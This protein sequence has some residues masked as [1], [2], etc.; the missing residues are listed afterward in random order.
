[1]TSD[2]GDR[3]NARAAS[4]SDRRAAAEAAELLI[5]Q[6]FDDDGLYAARSAVSARATHAGLAEGRVYDLVAA[7]HELAANAVQHGGGAGRLRLWHHN[8]ARPSSP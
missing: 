7:A 1:M 2:H 4:A 3:D 8:Q 5:D 6:I